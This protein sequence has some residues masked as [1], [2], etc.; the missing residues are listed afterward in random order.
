MRLFRTGSQLFPF[1][2]ATKSQRKDYIYLKSFSLCYVKNGVQEWH[3]GDCCRNEVGCL[4]VSRSGWLRNIF[5]DRTHGNWWVGCKNTGKGGN[6]MALWEELWRHDSLDEFGDIEKGQEN[7]FYCNTHWTLK[8]TCQIGICNSK[9]IR[10]FE[11]QHH[12]C[13]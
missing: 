4:D 6:R 3:Q 12:L 8:L 10:M 11:N 1:V 13:I 9:E 2:S 7:F 5:L